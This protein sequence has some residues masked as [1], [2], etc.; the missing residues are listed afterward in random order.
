MLD[1]LMDITEAESGMMIAP[2]AGDLRQRTAC[3]GRGILLHARGGEAY[4]HSHGLAGHP[5][6]PHRPA[7]MRQA[8]ANL[9]DNA[10]KY[11]A[12]GGEI[13]VA[14]R[15]QAGSVIVSIKDNGT[16]IPLEEQTR[17]WDRLYRGG[18]LR[19]TA[20]PRPRP[21]PRESRGGS[22]R[23]QGVS[24]QRARKRVWIITEIPA[25]GQRMKS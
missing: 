3:R 15:E 24:C 16:G 4:R 11:T 23:R 19:R 22:T 6:G 1:V 5:R 21:E 20:R 18:K 7:R 25:G 8:F 10:L 17:I 14:C 12:E 13:A 9:L 2:S